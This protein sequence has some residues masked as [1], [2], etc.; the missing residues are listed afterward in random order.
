MKRSA[1]LLL[2]RH[3]SRGV[4]VLIVH[5]SGSYNKNSPW[6]LPKGMP[7]PDEELEAAARRETLEEC[8]IDYRG[9]LTPLGHVV[10]KNGKN[11]F[12]FAGNMVE[13]VPKCASWEIDAAEFV[14][15]AVARERLHK[16]QQMFLDKLLEIIPCG[17]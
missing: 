4:E 14:L 10:Y 6:S 3:T 16:A 1:G 7:D 13:C 5:P 17:R 9:D 15:L 11:V 12:A 8:G 2:W